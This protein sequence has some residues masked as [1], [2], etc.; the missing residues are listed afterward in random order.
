[1]NSIITR[2]ERM[3]DAIEAPIARFLGVKQIWVSRVMFFIC[4]GSLATAVYM[5]C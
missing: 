1:M 5:L 2:L 4:Y 3:N